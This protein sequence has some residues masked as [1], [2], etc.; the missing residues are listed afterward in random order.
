MSLCS[1][2][3]T[4][5]SSALSIIVASI[6]T[7]SVASCTSNATSGV[8]FDLSAGIEYDARPRSAFPKATCVSQNP[9][10]CSERMGDVFASR[11]LAS[12]VQL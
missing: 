7:S 8:S 2:R 12:K 6:W 9:A 4:D 3:V 1:K 10:T 5:A 11:I